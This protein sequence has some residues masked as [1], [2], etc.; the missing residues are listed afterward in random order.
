MQFHKRLR[1]FRR[2]LLQPSSG[3]APPCT[4]NSEAD[5]SAGLLSNQ[6]CLQPSCGSGVPVRIGGSPTGI[7]SQRLLAMSVRI[8]LQDGCTH[9]V[10]SSPHEIP[11][12]RG[13]KNWLGAGVKEFRVL[14]ISL[15]SRAPTT[16]R[17]QHGNG[18]HT[19]VRST[20]VV[21]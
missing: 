11:M 21:A 13:T 18:S 10:C 20:S 2:I 6:H 12:N 5:L 19:G 17:V 7:R 1:M 4:A 15:H 14:V 9:L 8:A 16:A 3:Y